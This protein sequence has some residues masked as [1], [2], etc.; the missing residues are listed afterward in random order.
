M[1]DVQCTDFKE[2]LDKLISDLKSARDEADEVEQCKILHRIF[3]DDFEV[4]DAK[5]VSKPQRNYIPFS[6]AS[7][8]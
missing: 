1:T 8:V 2:K 6:S 3:G 5:D 4:P 7:G